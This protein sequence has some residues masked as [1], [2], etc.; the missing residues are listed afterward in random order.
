MRNTRPGYLLFLHISHFPNAIFKFLLE[1]EMHNSFI[2]SVCLHQISQQ[3]QSSLRQKSSWNRFW[4]VLCLLNTIDSPTV[5]F[6]IIVHPDEFLDAESLL[7]LISLGSLSQLV[8]QS[9]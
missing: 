9:N 3:C 8:S 1:L 5:P 2:P 6:V 7:I 4:L